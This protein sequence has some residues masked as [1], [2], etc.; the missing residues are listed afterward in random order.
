VRVLV[1]GGG[2]RE[3]A[4]TWALGRSPLLS[5]LYVAPGNGGTE[6][7]AENIAIDPQDLEAVLDIVR[8]RDIDLTVVGPEAPLVDGI[9]D[10]LADA[11]R[12]CF[13]PVKS[14]ARLEGSKVFAKE[15]MKRHGV[16]TAEFSLFDDPAEAKRYVRDKGCP[17]VIKADGLAQGKGVVVAGDEEAAC[18]ALDSIMVER[19]HGPS[20]ERVVVETCL[21]GDEV[22]VHAVC[23]GDRAV[24]FPASQDHKRIFEHDR[25][26][27]T[28]GMGAYAPV[29]FL[30]K[31]Q[32]DDIQRR[33]IRPTLRGMAAEGTPYCG[34][35]YAGLMI[36]RDGPSVLE[37]NVRFGDPETQVILPLLKSDLLAL[38][39]STAVHSAPGPV[40]FHEDRFAACVVAASQGY[41]G[42]YEKGLPISGLDNADDERRIVFHAGTAKGEK[43]L[44]TSGGR[45]LSMT[46]WGDD[47]ADALHHAYDGLGT[48]RFRG[49]Y[50]RSDIGHRAL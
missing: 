48:I 31:D 7:L 25:G 37:F 29:P 39:H 10:R 46:A 40:E 21:E 33:I 5:E 17:I 50:W 13:G 1:L 16:P 18:N 36:T 32:L 24:L 15:F 34:V 11:G 43:G 2:G 38:L 44:V 12:P 49:A 4:L 19:K 3:H 9:V 30:T 47:L 42:A 23:D 20:G 22:S 41:P 35:L 26:P 8:E 6:S 28:G 27:N 45:V 14:A